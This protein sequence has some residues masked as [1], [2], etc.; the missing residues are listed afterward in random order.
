MP[1][2]SIYLPDSL[3][4]QAQEKGLPLSA[5]AQRAVERA[6]QQSSTVEWVAR[7]RSRET[8]FRGTIDTAEVLRRARDEFGE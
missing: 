7:V 6:L 1:K 4:R 8:R 3:Y 2:V 5:L